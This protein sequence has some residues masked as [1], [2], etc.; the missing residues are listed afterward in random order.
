MLPLCAMG[1][2]PP[3]FAIRGPNLGN[4]SEYW[5][6]R[7][8]SPF[9]TVVDRD[10]VD[11]ELLERM[12]FT[13]ARPTDFP[14]PADAVRCERARRS[15]PRSGSVGPDGLLMGDLRPS[16]ARDRAPRLP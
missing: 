8:H 3:S 10:T 12:P 9:P 15:G 6:H 11:P 13:W 16:P 4:I 7:E 5:E 1:H 14:F 2:P